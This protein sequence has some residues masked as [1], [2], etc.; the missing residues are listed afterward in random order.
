[1]AT[2]SPSFGEGA[3]ADLVEA[4][5]HEIGY[6]K[7]IR[8]DAGNV[9]GVLFGRE[10]APTPLLNC[11]MDTAIA[12]AVDAPDVRPA[13]DGLPGPGPA[14]CK[15]GLAA[16]VYAGA[17]LKRSLLPLRGNLVVAATVAEENGASA[18]VRALLERRLPE[19]SLQ[20]AYAILGEP[21]D[22]GLYYGHD[23]W[24]EF[25]ILVE[26]AEPVP[27]RRRRQRHLQRPESVRRLP[28]GRF[29]AGRPAVGDPV[30]ALPRRLRTGGRRS[31]P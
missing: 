12:G 11:H 18:G 7:V 20:P 14:D 1:M 25:D 2:P 5:M 8:D 19:L 28:V 9:V 13:R 23:G 21:T 15:G 6:D 10:A 31:S 26:G 27:G 29:G 17:L 16:Q 4:K 30:A 22:L 24:V 3:V